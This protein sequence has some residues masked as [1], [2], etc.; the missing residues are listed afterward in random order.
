[1]NS[2]KYLN[3]KVFSCLLKYLGIIVLLIVTCANAYAA[4]PETIKFSSR[5]GK[6]ELIG[7]LFKPIEPGPRAAIVMLHGRA[8]S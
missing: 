2:L 1:M 4:T 5:D 8:G 6:T 3:F 7:Y